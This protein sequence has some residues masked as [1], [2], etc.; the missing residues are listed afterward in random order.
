A[1]TQTLTETITLHDALPILLNKVTKQY[2]TVAL[3]GDGGDESFLGYSHFDSLVRNKKIIDIPYF[4]RNFIAQSGVLKL[5]GMNSHRIID[6]KSTR[7]NSS[8][9]KISYAV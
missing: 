3:S 9:V 6:R 2:V 1:A 4:I 8:H 7:L 5:F